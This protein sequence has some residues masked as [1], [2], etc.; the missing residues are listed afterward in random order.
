MPSR[1]PHARGTAYPMRGQHQGPRYRAPQEVLQALALELLGAL[2][3]AEHR[4]AP[5]TLWLAGDPGLLRDTTR[6]AIVGSRDASEEGLARARRL[7]S[8]LAT[9]GVV[10]VS[11]LARGID[12]AAHEGAIRAGGRTIA[13]LGTPLTR[14]S[15]IDN[16]RLQE[17]IAA[18]HLLVS[19]FPPTHSTF[20][21]DFVA[22]NRTMALFS[23]ASIIVEAND[24]S[25]SLSQAAETVRLGKP[26]FFLQSVLDNDKLEWPGRFQ[27]SGAI[28]L[29]SSSQVI[30]VL[31]ARHER[32]AAG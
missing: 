18:N 27:A 15:P 2:S 4:Y 6:V 8:E 23:H 20:P 30:D 28:V 13:V 24:G 31:A 7:A 5:D 16:A 9:A 22:R 14:C 17:E 11:G 3:S 29:K 12:R 19:Q 26:L 21:S 25:G 32:A 1:Q 10:V